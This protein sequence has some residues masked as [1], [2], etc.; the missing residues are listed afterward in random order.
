MKSYNVC[1]QWF[2]W[3]RLRSQSTADEVA[4]QL[5]SS[6]A[7]LAERNRWLW[8]AWRWIRNDAQYL[9]V[10]ASRFSALIHVLHEHPNSRERWNSWWHGFVRDMDASRLIAELGFAAR[11]SFAS[12]LGRRLQ[13]QWLPTTPDTRDLATLAEM[14][15]PSAI[16]PRWL[17]SLNDTDLQSLAELVKTPDGTAQR[18]ALDM[19][20]QALLHSMG[21]VM[22]I[23]FQ[24]ELR[25]RMDE[26]SQGEQ[27]FRE[28]PMRLERLRLAVLQHGRLSPQALEASQ[29][30]RQQLDLAR[31]AAQTV[32]NHLD[33]YG[34]SVGI[35]FSLR[36][37]RKRILRIRSL[38]N[39]L[40]SPDPVAASLRLLAQLARESENTRGIRALV[41]NN[42]SLTA[43][44]VAERSAE[45]GEHYITRNRNEARIMLK[46]SLGGGAVIG[47]TTWI[48]FGLVGLGL[49][50]F[51][52]GFAAGLNYALSF[53]LVMWLHWTIATKQPAFTAAAMADKLR[54]LQEPQH[55]EGFVDEVVHLL[56]SQ[57]VA[58]MGNLMAVVPATA[59]L[60]YGLSW[61]LGQNDLISADKALH[62]LESLHVLGPTLL[63]ATITGFLLFASSIVAGWV[64]N[65]FVLH[66]IDSVIEH[67]PHSIRWLGA[68]R[69]Q[70][71]SL[72]WRNHISGWAANISLGLMLGLTPA[73]AHFIGLGLDVRHVT[74]SAGQ[75][76]GAAWTLGMDAFATPSFWWALVGVLMVGPMNLVVSFYL[77]FRLAMAA[78]G[79]RVS[80]RHRIGR[81]IRRRLLSHPRSLLWPNQ[82]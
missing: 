3:R 56:R 61:I 15:R 37:L 24:P 31:N 43:A 5:P 28:L 69:A 47:L 50:M 80:Q 82:K 36:Q 13:L 20:M 62:T 29:A 70:R 73:F 79:V 77:A 67:H 42:A 63:F 2:F 33:R 30:V 8:L 39:T 21:Q 1:M 34:I 59:L 60:A 22:A 4:Q 11:P 16:D 7:S 19:V 68:L 46:A 64:E 66:R 6:H 25:M 27:A 12:E 72:Y 81:S 9:E 38:L 48:K 52:E 40:H 45:N 74:L 26:N 57:T 41:V 58:I 71:W 23:G 51:W 65:A 53:L 78:R 18:W 55:V 32:Y 54:N 44:R 75:L 14:L 17:C 35:V 76:V 49:S 10:S